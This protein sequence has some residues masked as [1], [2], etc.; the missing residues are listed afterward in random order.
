MEPGLS[1]GGREPR[2]GRKEG[3]WEMKRGAGR[4]QHLQR[5]NNEL[6]EHIT[7]QVRRI[8]DENRQ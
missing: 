3:V 7:V 5:I 8:K 6:T 2:E 4:G 1:V